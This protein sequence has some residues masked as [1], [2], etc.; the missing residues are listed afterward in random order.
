MVGADAR[1]EIAVESGAADERA[2]PVDR[3]GLE[4]GQ[5]GEAGRVA[6]EQ[7]GKIHE[8]REAQNLR[9]IGERQEVADFEPRARRL[10]VRR[11]HA[12]RKL[13]AQVHRGRHRAVEKVAQTR[14]SEHVA[15]LVRIADRRGHAVPQHAAVEFERCDERGLHMAVGVDEPRNDDFSADVDLFDA[16]V[17][18]DR[19][20][21]AVVADRDVA[22]HEVAADEIE[23]PPALEHDV[24]LGEPLAL[25]D[26]AGEIGDGVAHDGFLGDIRG[27]VSGLNGRLKGREFPLSSQLP[28]S[29]ASSAIK[30]FDI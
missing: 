16:A 23:D 8:F 18:A 27:I 4:R 13:D 17:L 12:A 5:L 7:A 6:G 20:D 10:E 22:L 3:P 14:L 9:V 21:D 26:R 28:I 29:S 2:V 1:A 19:P 25:L 30:L 24:G 15:D 11:R